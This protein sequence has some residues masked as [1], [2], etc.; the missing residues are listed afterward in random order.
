MAVGHKTGGRKKGTKNKKTVALEVAAQKVIDKLGNVIGEGNIFQGDAH[1]YLM[2]VYKD[3]NQPEN[4]RLD[5]AKAA[6][7]FE[8]P[9]LAHIESKNETEVRYVARVPTKAEKPDEWQQQHTPQSLLSF[10]KPNVDRKAH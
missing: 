7:R 2:T 10:G 1:A 9:Q 8:R 4:F 3:P 6:I 5:A